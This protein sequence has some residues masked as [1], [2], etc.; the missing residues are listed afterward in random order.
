MALKD[1]IQK[2]KQSRI[3]QAISN[4]DRDKQLPGFQLQQ[5]GL[6]SNA[7]KGVESFVKPFYQ[8]NYQQAPVRSVLGAPARFVQG[9]GQNIAQSANLSG[10]VLGQRQESINQ[11]MQGLSLADRLKASLQPTSQENKLLLSGAYQGAKTLAQ[12]SPGTVGLKSAGQVALTGGL[13]SVIS[14]GISALQG[15]DIASG[16]GRGFGEGLGFRTVTRFT[17]PVISKAVG[18]IAPKAGFLAKQVAQR[19]T[20]G[21]GNVIEDEI[22][23]KL[24]GTKQETR[25]RV[26]SLVLGATM[27]GNEDLFKKLK[28]N[29]IDSGIKPQQADIVV[30]KVEQLRDQKGRYAKEGFKP[31]EEL[32]NPAGAGEAYKPSEYGLVQTGPRKFEQQKLAKSRLQPRKLFG[33][34][35]PDMNSQ[36]GAIRLGGEISNGPQIKQSSSGNIYIKID[37]NQVLKLPKTVQNDLFEVSQGN[38]P[39]PDRRIKINTYLNRNG[40]EMDAVGRIEKIETINQPIGKPKGELALIEQQKIKGQDVSLKESIA[41]PSFGDQ[42]SIQ[43][44]TQPSTLSPEQ[45]QS[46]KTTAGKIKS[47]RQKGLTFQEQKPVQ[48]GSKL[49]VKPE[50]MAKVGP[51]KVSSDVSISRDKKYSFNI[52]KKKLGLNKAQSKELDNVVEAMRPVLEKNKGKVLTKQEIIEGGRKAKV[53]QD[54][55]GRDEAKQ[56]AESLQAS[57]NLLRSEQAQVGI[58]PKFLEQLEIISSV[59]ADAGR[60]LQSFNIGA[61]DITIKEKVLRDILKVGADANEVLKAGK[62]VDWNDAKQITDFYRKFKPATLADMLDE[63]R[64]TNM[65]SSPST[66]ITNAFSNLLQTAVLA[67]VEKSVRGAVSFAESRL[68]GKEQ[69]YFARQGVDY[70]RGYWK[71]LPEALNKFVST[72]KGTEGI[73]KPDL[74]LIPTST[75]KIRQIYTLP[76]QALEASDQFFRTLVKGGE[77]ESLK[78]QGITGA[79]A[80]KLAEQSADYRTFRQAF[81]PNGT[82]GQNKVLQVWDKWNT[83]IQNLRNVPGGKYLVPFLQTPTNI[84]KQGVEYSPLGFSTVK[85]S[86]NPTEQLAKAIIG[87]SIFSGAYALADSGLTT[88]D[89]PTNPT[90]KAE[91]YAAGLQPYSIKIG[92]RWVS[93]SKLGPLSYP[94]AMASALKWAKDN[95]AGEDQLATIGGSISGTLG[96]FADQSFVRG[97]GDI[98]DAVKG[99]EYKQAR[100]LSNIPAQMVPYRSAMGWIA[101]LV[102][103]V[104]RKTS[105][106]SV[107]E[108]VQKSIVSQIPYASKT[109]EAY[110]TPF[111]T[112]SVRQF[113]WTNAVSPLSISQEKPKE[114][115]YYDARQKIRVQNKEAD[116]I[117]KKIEAGENVDTSKILSKEAIALT[118]KKIEAG[119]EV[120]PQELETA[121]LSN[122]TSMPKGNRYEKSN[123]DSKLWSETTAIINDENLSDAQKDVLINK[124]AE[125]LGGGSAV[126]KTQIGNLSV[127][128]KEPE[129]FPFPDFSKSAPGQILRADLEFEGSGDADIVFNFKTPEGRVISVPQAKET[130][131]NGNGSEYEGGGYGLELQIPQGIKAGTGEVWAT[132]N[133]KEVAGTRRKHEIINTQPVNR[134]ASGSNPEELA[135]SQ[136]EVNRF[137]SSNPTFSRPEINLGGGVTKDDIILYQVA[138]DTNNNKTLYTYDQMDKMQSPEE[139]YR[140]LTEGRKPINGQILISDG[141]I[142]NLVDDGII[143][144]QLGKEL[145]AIDYNE[146]GA[147]KRKTRGGGS[148]KKSAESKAYSNYLKA[149]SNISLPSG[150]IRTQAP[151]R[152]SV[153]GLTFSD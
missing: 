134:Y 51:S 52:N 61:E 137:R 22:I 77:M 143:P 87:T 115:E 10:Q 67:P 57:R 45:F 150:K 74:D 39:K 68:T 99:D 14:G 54:V 70:A 17:D 3:G 133:G 83:A 20:S 140:Y 90:E 44:G 147:L 112:E 152:A 118:K 25:D 11:R 102:D 89:T 125:E 29:L 12:V 95:G 103:P 60:R 132:V 59:A 36:A 7:R 18:A 8:P 46:S 80:T 15:Q 30:K 2:A 53:L 128:T 142:D 49:Q 130:F 32:F 19:S 42:P 72:L 48:G 64:Y 16:A 127:R 79:R 101:R 117:L 65:L 86:A 104:Y 63:Y 153:K 144:Y 73:T 84:L 9:F 4:L 108:Q 105:G 75:S 71:A 110:K 37:K 149:L 93:Y 126:P 66:H 26:Y 31:Q 97:I 123:R 96:F 50:V 92:D 138:K 114:K 34:E 109:L 100:G 145:K 139:F 121:Y 81:D 33:I 13:P 91:F 151:I 124:I 76:L 122:I 94:I 40:L 23:S 82:L 113:P 58:T 111:G 135:R 120:T 148:S 55:V 129:N 98:I 47:Q 69:E 35:M 28:G 146:N 116:K 41:Q 5:G 1:L 107:L 141:V 88:W 27:G 131:N 56:F 119:I 38:I 43:K 85:G 136:A 21:L 62:N 78:T 106:G 6:V 24:E